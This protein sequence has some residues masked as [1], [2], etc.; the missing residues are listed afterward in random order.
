LYVD[1]V[2]AMVV[3]TVV[4]VTVVL[5]A[6]V[7]TVVEGT[8]VVAEGVGAVEV[9]LEAVGE[10]AITDVDVLLDTES[11]EADDAAAVDADA[12]TAGVVVEGTVGW[13]LVVTSTVVVDGGVEAVAMVVV[14]TGGHVNDAK[15]VKED[16]VRILGL[17][18]PL[19]LNRLQ[20]PLEVWWLY[21][22]PSAPTAIC[23]SS[24]VELNV[25]RGV[26]TSEVMLKDRNSRVN[27]VADA[28][29]LDMEAPAAYN[30]PFASKSMSP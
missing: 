10:V 9:A 11:V 17:S 25:A 28:C 6:V 26:L 24:V 23:D 27:T 18:T 16:V 8:V 29:V 21:T 3:V 1:V 12:V 22:C 13:V 7:V 14:E 2:V 20:L 19:M 4:V 15:S 30:N 5:A